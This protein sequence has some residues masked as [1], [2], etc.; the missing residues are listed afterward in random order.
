MD[1]VKIL[2]EYA[3]DN[4]PCGIR[5]RQ[6]IEEIESKTGLDEC[7]LSKALEQIP[8]VGVIGG[9]NGIGSIEINVGFPTK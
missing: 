1:L 3:P 9:S 8:N 2:I 7:E 5:N 4:R 6:I